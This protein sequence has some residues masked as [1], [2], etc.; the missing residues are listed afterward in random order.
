MDMNRI[1]IR[2]HRI[3]SGYETRVFFIDGRP[4]YEYFNSWV[5][6]DDEVWARLNN[7][8][9][10]EITWGGVMD[11]E[12]DNR[13]IRFLLQQ[14][15]VC[16]PVLSCP[17]DMDFNCI[18]IVADV[19]KENGKVLW[20]RLGI[21]NN[22]RESAWPSAEYGIRHYDNFT[23]EEWDLYG[24]I[25][26]EPEDSQKY[27]EWISANWSEELYRRRINYIYP[28]LQ[29]EENMTWFVD[30]SFEFDSE[31]Y[32]AVVRSCYQDE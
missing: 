30:C 29:N 27:K 31:E 26:F 18:L 17:D 32:E 6:K 4:L 7:P 16:L 2:R 28:F 21:V 25:V 20:K 10:L 15:K 3:P 13:F 24:D 11:S 1:E 23:D 8:D 14:D 9:M 5:S 12:G 19:V 22:T